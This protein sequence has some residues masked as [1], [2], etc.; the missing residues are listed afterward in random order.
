MSEQPSETAA[1]T[2]GDPH[3]GDSGSPP[4]WLLEYGPLFVFLGFYRFKDIY[5]ATGAFMVALT[6]AMAAA[7]LRDRKLP[8]PLIFSG[9]IVLP[10]GA[11]TIWWRNPIFIYVKPTIVAGVSALVL[12][13][14]LLR[15]KA[16]LKSLI[17][18]QLK[19]SDEGWR[20][21]SLRFALF[22]LALAG[23]NELVWR[24]FEQSNWVLFKFP[25][26]PLLTAVFLM[27]QMPLLKRHQL[28]EPST[29][30]DV[31]EAERE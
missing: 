27:T 19:L 14:G 31:P 2:A 20:A 16:L 8:P 10:L 29:R 21:L 7:W 12:L 28:D 9:A 4:K 3:A 25:G 15:G 13:G 22:S 11:L 23:T 5:W 24:S 26:I 18:P 6:V 1:R 17:G 30:G